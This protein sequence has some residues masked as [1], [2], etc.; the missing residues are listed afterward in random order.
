MV[1]AGELERSLSRS[2][3]SWPSGV[4]D[5]VR[6]IREELERCRGILDGMAARAGDIVGERLETLGADQVVADALAL[7]RDEERHRVEVICQG[8]APTILA[9]RRALGGAV[10]NLLRNAMQ[11]DV[12]EAP[13]I[14]QVSGDGTVGRLSVRDSG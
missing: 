9:P 11:A 5:D 6:L 14:V 8:P 7:L 3:S 2:A 4:A 13:I 1:A 12:Q 10:A